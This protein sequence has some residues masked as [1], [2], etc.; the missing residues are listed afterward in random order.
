MPRKK[1]VKSAA[2]K[3]QPSKQVTKNSIS[4]LQKLEKDFS[5]APVKFAEQ[6]TK[7]IVALKQKE[8]KLNTT[9]SKIQSQVTKIEKS[10]AVAQKAKTAAGKKQVA[11]AKKVLNDTKKDYSLSIAALKETTNSLVAAE[12]RLAR[13]AALIKALKQFDKDWAAHAKKLKEKA[14]AVEKAKAEAKAKTAA[15]ANAKKAKASKPKA[16]AAAAPVAE[17]APPALTVIEQPD[18]DSTADESE[19]DEVKQAIS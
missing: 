5:E 9:I 19:F 14:K 13:N 11:A 12:L 10:I 1:V 18:F 6:L 7:E 16:R 4:P 3:K 15:K 8:T 2:R 17:K